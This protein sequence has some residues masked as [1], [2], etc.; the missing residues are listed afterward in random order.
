MKNS[1]CSIVSRVYKTH[2]ASRN[3]STIPINVILL[4]VILQEGA[5][6]Y[7]NISVIFIKMLIVTAVK[8]KIENLDE[9]EFYNTC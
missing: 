8:I 7:G 6:C 3:T 9:V 4:V 2:K 5:S 1:A